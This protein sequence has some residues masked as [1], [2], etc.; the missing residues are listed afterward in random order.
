MSSKQEPVAWAV[1]KRGYPPMFSL[2]DDWN[3]AC[4]TAMEENG[5]IVPLYRQPQ[6]TLT[7]A[8][9]EAVETAAYVNADA[10][11]GLLERLA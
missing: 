4:R 8:E 6:P 2:H 9:R 11:R 5:T 3:G 7:D 1:E 10:L